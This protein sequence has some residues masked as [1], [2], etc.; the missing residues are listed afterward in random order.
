MSNSCDILLSQVLVIRRFAVEFGQ[1]LSVVVE[2]EVFGFGLEQAKLA[3]A[4][5]ATASEPSLRQEGRRR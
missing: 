5:A 4:V 2:Q 1:T 3:R